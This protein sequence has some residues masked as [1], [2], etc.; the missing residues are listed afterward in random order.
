MA[1]GVVKKMYD[2]AYNTPNRGILIDL[3]TG[4]EYPFRRPDTE[5]GKKTERWNVKEKDAVTFTLTGGAV[6]GVTLLRKH[7]D[8]VVFTYTPES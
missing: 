4:I 2:Y 3:E 6:S 5:S 7:T 1:V 8:G